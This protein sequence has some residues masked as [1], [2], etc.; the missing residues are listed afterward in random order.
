MK[1]T[2]IRSIATAAGRLAL[3]A[4][5]ALVIAACAEDISP[6]TA[7][8]AAGSAANPNAIVF[9]VSDSTALTRTAT[10]TIG[11]N[12]LQ[13]QGFGVFA[14]N[15]GFHKYASSSIS[16][17]FMYNE[18][19]SYTDPAWTYSPLKYWPNSDNA[20]STS[21]YISF[22]AYAPYA[23]APGTGSD[24]ASKCITDIVLPT[25]EGDPW[26]VYQLGGTRE[27]WQDS[28]VD[29]L[30]AVAKD[31][32]KQGP[33]G[34]VAFNFNHALAGLGD[35]LTVTC[36][37]GLQNLIR[38]KARTAGKR[39]TL[40]IDE[41]ILNYTLIKKAKLMLNNGT[42]PNWETINSDN[43]MEHRILRLMP[44]QLLATSPADGSACYVTE[45]QAHDVGLFYIP[46]EINGVNQVLD[47]SVAYT[48][49][50]D[51]ASSY[52]GMVSTRFFLN[53]SYAVPGKNHDF[54]FQLG[55][56][57]PLSASDLSEY[58]LELHVSDV[59][60]QTFT[61][62]SITPIVTVWNDNGILLS[63]G[64]D[65]TLRYVNNINVALST[66]ANPPMVVVTGVGDYFGKQAV[67]R[68]TINR[69]EDAIYFATTGITL[70]VGGTYINT[71]T[72][73]KSGD[74]VVTYS[75]SN[76]SVATVDAN[77]G[78]LTAVSAGTCT[79]TATVADLA[80]GNYTYPVKTVYYVVTVR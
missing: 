20:S 76:P 79:I 55:V 2:L 4:V 21:E 37:T 25:E 52:S 49:E 34:K 77:T 16:S 69:A 26:L 41:L 15:T 14:A 30:Y 18:K 10:G 57:T 31:Q 13:T 35:Q 72:K 38:N 51:G 9:S 53:G 60:P 56:S 12:E 58:S 36:N 48:C 11:I 27:D 5:S 73:S 70:S 46:L 22:F 29:L 39:V 45:F 43:Q 59:E 24:N 71:V 74:G 65:Y 42:V 47:V 23:A 66:S 17:N 40:T 7:T 54:N 61:N 28:Q 50:T 75:S 1:K 62:G 8:P 3:A 32:Q 63:E 19:V 67:K 78:E 6:E 80:G 44:N 68:F 64:I 33:T